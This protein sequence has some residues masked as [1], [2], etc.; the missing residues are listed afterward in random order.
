MPPSPEIP[1]LMNPSP[2]NSKVNVP[3]RSSQGNLKVNAPLPTLSPENSKVTQ[4]GGRGADKNSNS[5]ILYKPVKA[6]LTV[7]FVV[8]N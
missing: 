2:G 4:Q 6:L 7:H 8:K 3:P 5:P 1:G